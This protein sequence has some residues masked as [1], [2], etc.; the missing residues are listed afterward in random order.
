MRLLLLVI[1]A[2]LNRPCRC[3]LEQ[4]ARHHLRFVQTSV[5]QQ[6]L[7]CSVNRSSL[8]RNCHAKVRPSDPESLFL[9]GSVATWEANK[10]AN[11]PKIY[12]VTNIYLKIKGQRYSH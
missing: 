8:K 4:L 11:A 6:S 7:A 3:M 12:S 9:L 1:A 10:A 5:V 2:A